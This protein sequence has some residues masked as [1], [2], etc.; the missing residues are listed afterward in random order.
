[1]SSLQSHRG[2]TLVETVIATG[3]LVTALAGVAQLFFLS[4]QLTRQ[5]SASGVALAAAQDKLETLRGLTFSYSGT[6]APLTAPDLEPSASFSLDE[7]LHPNV[8][9]LDGEAQAIDDAAAASFVRR[10]RIST[11]DDLF[12]DAIAIEVCVF[13]APADADIRAADTCLSAIRTRQP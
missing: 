7:N 6:G 8:D 3:L 10:W 5:V 9:W 2:F 13:K 11:I 1:M 12:P 4:V